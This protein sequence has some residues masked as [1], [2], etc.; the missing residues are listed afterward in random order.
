MTAP[1]FVVGSPRSGTTLLYSVLLTSGVF[2]LYMAESKILPSRRHYGPWGKSRSRG[3][4]LEDFLG[5]RQF[6]RSGLDRTSLLEEVAAASAS[7]PDFLVNFM[8]AVAR[9]QGCD[10]WV[11]KTPAHVHWVG[12][13]AGRLPDARF[14][15]I[16]RDGRDVALSIRKAGWTPGW[17]LDP[18]TALV[19]AGLEWKRSVVSARTAERRLGPERFLQIRY[20]ELVAD[21]EGVLEKLS[22][23]AAVPLH[24]DAVE[25]SDIGSLG[26]P[27][28]VYG[29]ADDPSGGIDRDAVAR[30]RERLGPREAA[31]LEAAIGETLADF[32]YSVRSGRDASVREKLHVRRVSAAHSTYRRLKHLPGLRRVGSSPLEVGLD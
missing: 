12:E 18:G 20:E 13:L 15:H 26:R 29:G 2:P 27:N 25:S 21:R 3:R 5:S 32:G 9:A 19:Y 28:T 6:A 22:E 1:L 4:F 24:L 16:V 30:W 7:Y 10:R 14:L 11:E 23:F 17:C 31:L 8:D